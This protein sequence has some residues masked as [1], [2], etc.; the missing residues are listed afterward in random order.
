MVVISLKILVL[1]AQLGS[2][3]RALAKQAGSPK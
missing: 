3:N 2:Q 1:M